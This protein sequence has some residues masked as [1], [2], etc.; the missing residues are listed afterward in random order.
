MQARS[1]RLRTILFDLDGTVA[2]TAP[3]LAYALNIVLEEE[4]YPSFALDRVRPMV[5]LGGRALIE[6]AFAMG[7]E[8]AKSD[9]LRER[10]LQLYRQNLTKHTRLFPGIASV[11][12]HIEEQGM[13]WGIVTNKSAWLT[14]PLIEELGLTARAACVVSGDTT[15]NF[16]PHP[17]P[18]LHAC[19]EVGSDPGECIYIGDSHKDIEAGR[20]AGMQ[21]LVALFGYIPNDEDPSTWG[22]DSLLEIPEEL[23][24]WLELGA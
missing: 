8:H 19:A 20:R 22:A 4:G 16:K 3:D 14:N 23:I 12:D 21:T 1:H 5:S 9:H 2:D 10:F 7:P 13:N 15:N 24:D 17:E 18:L 6:A 11:L